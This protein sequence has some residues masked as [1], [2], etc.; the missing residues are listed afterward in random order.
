MSQKYGLKIAYFLQ[1]KYA[2]IIP[3]V[4]RCI[5]ETKNPQSKHKGGSMPN[6][7]KEVQIL[8]ESSQPVLTAKEFSLSLV[9]KTKAEL[10]SLEEYLTQEMDTLALSIISKREKL[11]NLKKNR[12]RVLTE[13]YARQEEK[14][15]KEKLQEARE[16]IDSI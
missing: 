14:E 12:E 8:N 10:E 15:E 1:K 11:K 6:T 3:Y 16:L 2:K 13:L 4:K 7:K 9:L 5:G